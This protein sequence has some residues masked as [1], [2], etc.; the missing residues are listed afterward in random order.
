M[1]KL[2]KIMH[3]LPSI[4]RRE[5]LQHSIIPFSLFLLPSFVYKPTS[6][7][8]KINSLAYLDGLRGVAALFVMI[9]H[10]TCQFAPALLEG[11]GNDLSADGTNENRWFFQLPLFRVIHSGSFMVVLFFAIS[12][13]VLSLR[14][15]RL[16]RQRKKPEFLSALA[17]AVFR[18]WLRLHLPV[19]ASMCIALFISRMEWWTHLQPDWLAPPRAPTLNTT[20]VPTNL[21]ILSPAALTAVEVLEEGVSNGTK[22]LARSSILVERKMR[23]QWDWTAATKNE[24]LAFQLTDFFFAVINVCDPFSGGQAPGLQAAGYNAGMILWTIPIEYFGSIVVFITL[25]GIAW[26]K[27]W[28]KLAMLGCLICWCHYTVKWHLA[29]FLYGTLIAELTLIKEAR[30]SEPYELPPCNDVPAVA[31]KKDRPI[32]VIDI[33]LSKISKP[34][35]STVFWILLF[36]TGIYI[37]SI[38]QINWGSS[39]GFIT[40]RYLIPEWYF[41]KD[42][43]Y[44]CLGAIFIM[45][46]ITYSPHIQFLF[47][48][49]IAQ[50]LGRISFSLYLLHT[51]ILCSLGIRVMSAAMNMVG[52]GETY[53]Q[54]TVGILVGA[55]VMVPATLWAAD[56]FCRGVDEK[57]VVSARWVAGKALVWA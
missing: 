10:Y 56:V 23:I 42:L 38:P 7:P 19:I 14:C 12:G 11:W 35:V 57:S 32:N 15:L 47:L 28:V 9:H 6:R 39:P 44:P 33:I 30:A 45:F 37:G 55:I 17:G 34:E 48:T 18:R 51:Q 24:S 27:T 8:R 25:L 43:F 4:S 3:F 52:G 29:T 40:L 20:I 54:F 26:T 13:C 53:F 22:I 46:S 2:R 31:D 16:G 49:P 5:Y 50:Y 21:T 36:V 41:A 1:L